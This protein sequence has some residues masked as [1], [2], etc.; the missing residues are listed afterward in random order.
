[1][2]NESKN[3][4]SHVFCSPPYITCP[5]LC[6][7]VCVYHGACEPHIRAHHAIIPIGSTGAWGGV[8]SVE[9]CGV[10][11]GGLRGC[12]WGERGGDQWGG[13]RVGRRKIRIRRVIKKGRAHHVRTKNNITYLKKENRHVLFRCR[14]GG[15][16]E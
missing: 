3:V 1:M 16:W 5:T 6:V 2:S 7:T 11:G 15:Y 9:G 10:G 14:F 13:W 12:R 8:W 4:D